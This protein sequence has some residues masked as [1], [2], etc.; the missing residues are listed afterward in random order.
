M[1]SYQQKNLSFLHL[2][3]WI[4]YVTRKQMRSCRFI[5]KFGDPHISK[6][7]ALL[8]REGVCLRGMLLLWDSEHA[9]PTFHDVCRPEGG[10]GKEEKRDQVAS[11]KKWL[12]LTPPSTA[13]CSGDVEKQVEGTSRMFYPQIHHS[14][15]LVF[16]PTVICTS[17]NRG[18]IARIFQKSCPH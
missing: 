9:A 7:D 8:K 17:V 5:L 11:D 2:E 16:L 12:H 3:L 18:V 6:W 1:T 4:I 14:D 13:S 10:G 15:R